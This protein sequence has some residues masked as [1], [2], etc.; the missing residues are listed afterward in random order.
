MEW[1][2]YTES[3]AVGFTCISL[4][5]WAHSRL[6]PFTLRYLLNVFGLFL[7]PK[8]KDFLEPFCSL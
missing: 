5:S 8:E 4:N 6:L 7:H 2:L 3:V 1:P